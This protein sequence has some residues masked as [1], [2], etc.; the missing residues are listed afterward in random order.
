MWYMPCADGCVWYGG[1]LSGHSCV[2][3]GAWRRM[4]PSPDACCVRRESAGVRSGCVRGGVSAGGVLAG[5]SCVWYGAW[6]RMPPSPDACCV[7]R[8]SVGVRTGCVRSVE[9]VTHMLPKK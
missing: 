6:R 4:P 7:R 8:E 1:V 5:R 9:L 2:R 3:Y